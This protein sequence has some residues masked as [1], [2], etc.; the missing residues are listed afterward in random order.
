MD[1]P[2]VLLTITTT[3][4]ALQAG[5]ATTSFSIDIDMN[6]VAGE[7]PFEYVVEGLEQSSS[8]PAGFDMRVSVMN[9]AGYG[10]PSAVLNVKVG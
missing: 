6:V 4:S 2:Y 5:N 10:R 3:L 1:I 8:E 7:V 9:S